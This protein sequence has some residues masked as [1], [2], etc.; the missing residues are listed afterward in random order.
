MGGGHISSLF[1][2]SSYHE[3][4]LGPGIG[5]LWQEACHTGCHDMY[6]EY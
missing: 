4:I 6:N 2:G 1:S 5:Q 3:H